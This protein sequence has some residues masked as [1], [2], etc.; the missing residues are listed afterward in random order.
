MNSSSEK[1]IEMLKQ[2]ISEDSEDVFLQYALALEYV[3]LDRREDALAMLTSIIANHPDYLAAYYQLGKLFEQSRLPVDAKKTYE[4]GIAV[5]QQ[6]KEFK[7]LNEL[8]A[9]LDSMED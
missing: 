3:N 2:Y 6:Q 1:R 5:A 8:R 7:T 9:A 4:A